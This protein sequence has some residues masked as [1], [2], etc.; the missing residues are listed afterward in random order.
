[1]KGERRE[2]GGEE[3]EEDEGA[4][5]IGAEPNGTLTGIPLNISIVRSTEF[6]SSKL[7]VY[8]LLA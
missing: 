7:R 8:F 2:E 6:R 4:E 5:E 3:E 1:M